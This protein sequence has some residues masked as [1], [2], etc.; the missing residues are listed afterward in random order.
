M[1]KIVILIGSFLMTINLFGQNISP[2]IISAPKT[3]KSSNKMGLVDSKKQL[4]IWLIPF[5]NDNELATVFDQGEQKFANISSL[6]TTSI[7]F[8]LDTSSSN[9]VYVEL[10]SLIPEN[11]FRISLGTQIAQTFLNDTT[12]TN[13]EIAYQK[14]TNGGGNIS[15]NFSRPIVYF[16]SIGVRKNGFF[17][18]N[19][20][21]T[22]YF[23]IEK[24]NQELYNPGAGLFL[25]TEFDL[26][27]INHTLSDRQPGNGFR[28]G[29][30]GGWQYNA[31][32]SKYGEKYEMDEKFD[33]LH[34][35]SCGVYFGFAL[36]NLSISR[37]FYSSNDAFFDEKGWS[38]KLSLIPVKL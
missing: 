21:L 3:E 1:K 2:M 19:A 32:N 10:I 12:R 22:P 4:P 23:D 5:R 31:F 35:F 20:S 27:L 14:L 15:L 18:M 28:F 38:I 6:K 30:N 34:I 9:S 29:I 37:H 33:N 16:D 36:G 13:E 25:S 11:W 26:R 8:S 24:L 17:I 7:N